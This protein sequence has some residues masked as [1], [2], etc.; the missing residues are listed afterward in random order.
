MIFPTWHWPM[1]LLAGRREFRKRN[2]RR[3]ASAAF[4]ALP[5]R[6]KCPSAR[7]LCAS[8][9]SLP[10]AG[11]I[12]ACLKRSRAISNKFVL[13]TE[14]IDAATPIGPFIF[15]IAAALAELERSIIRERTR[16]GLAPAPEAARAASQR[17]STTASG[18][19]SAPLWRLASW[20]LRS[21]PPG[22]TRAPRQSTAACPFGACSRLASTLRTACS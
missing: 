11:S 10:P 14:A 13:R 16:A 20:R 8:A 1:R 5:A 7:P 9:A 4:A 15:H 17:S 12:A 6:K 21:P 18:V 3:G 19:Q 2:S 22:M